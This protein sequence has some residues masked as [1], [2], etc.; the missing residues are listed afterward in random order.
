MNKFKACGSNRYVSPT[1]EER[2]C[3]HKYFG[4]NSKREGCRLEQSCDYDMHRENDWGCDAPWKPAPCGK[5]YHHCD[6]MTSCTYHD[7]TACCQD[8]VYKHEQTCRMKKPCVESCEHIGNK[9]CYGSWGDNFFDSFGCGDVSMNDHCECECMD[10]CSCHKE[11]CTTPSCGG[12]NEPASCNCNHHEHMDC[13]N[14][15]GEGMFMPNYGS[16]TCGCKEECVKPC[17]CDH[18]EHDCD[19]SHHDGY[20]YDGCGCG[21]YDGGCC[22]D[23]SNHAG[24]RQRVGMAYVP[25]QNWKEVYDREEGFL[26]G[27]IFPDLN[28]PFKGGNCNE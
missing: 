27:T 9:E 23:V 12:H 13:G 8:P 4:A 25:M 26:N 7:E 22:G 21:E 14:E 3:N 20:H 24:G 2:R 5:P 17:S 6:D 10:D 18:R 15:R 11:T 1:F 28:K 16:E 19:H